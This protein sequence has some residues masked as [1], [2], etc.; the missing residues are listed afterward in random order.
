[1]PVNAIAWRLKPRYMRTKELWSRYQQRIIQRSLLMLGTPTVRS[2][3]KSKVFGLF[4]A[5]FFEPY[6]SSVLRSYI[7]TGQ[8]LRLSSNSN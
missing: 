5:L 7:S 2:P 8:R 4:N 6:L 1:M 3:G